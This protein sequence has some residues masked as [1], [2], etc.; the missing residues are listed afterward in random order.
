MITQDRSYDEIY[1]L[2]ALRVITDS[3]Q[4]RYA[5]LGIIH[6]RWTPIQGRFHDYVATPK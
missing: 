6:S 2:M 1:D 3:V 4:H 5:A